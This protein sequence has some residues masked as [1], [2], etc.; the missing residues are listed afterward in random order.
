M[1]WFPIPGA[2]P[3][4]RRVPPGKWWAGVGRRSARALRSLRGRLRRR[5][6]PG[7]RTPGTPCLIG[8]ATGPNRHAVPTGRSRAGAFLAP[9]GWLPQ[10]GKH[11]ARAVSHRAASRP[12]GLSR[13]AASRLSGLSLPAAKPLRCAAIHRRPVATRRPSEPSRSAGSRPPVPVQPNRAGILPAPRRTAEVTGAGSGAVVVEEAEGGRGDRSWMLDAGYW[14]L[15]NRFQHLASSPQPCAARSPIPSPSS[16]LP[17][18]PGASP[19]PPRF[20]RPCRD[21]G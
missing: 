12:S 10:S 11:L 14:M 5:A 13:P 16:P 6:A 15:G 3:G 9:S 17:G 2:G 21:R 1:S 8:G 4:V 18:A 20:P 7:D 19:S